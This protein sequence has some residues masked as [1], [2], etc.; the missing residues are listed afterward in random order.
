M[1]V[2][3]GGPRDKSKSLQRGGQSLGYEHGV[4]GG[5]DSRGG[6]S[7][8]VPSA[9]H[10]NSITVAGGTL[11]RGEGAAKDGGGGGLDG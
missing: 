11:W 8:A 2:N 9:Q 1:V 7:G 6:A 10:S 3:C 4:K 5:S